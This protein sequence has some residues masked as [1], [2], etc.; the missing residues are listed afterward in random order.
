MNCKLVLSLRSQF[1]HRRRFFSSQAKL[2]ST[3][4]RWGITLNVCSSLRLAICTR[5]VLAQ[6]ILDPLGERL[7]DLTAIGQHTLHSAQMSLATFKCLQGTLAIRHFRRCD[8]HG[9]R[10]PLRYPRQCVA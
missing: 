10:Q 5:D 2:R 1:F 6:D 8:R 4:H 3:I 7:A 9:M